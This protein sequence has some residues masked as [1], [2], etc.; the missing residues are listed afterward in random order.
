MSAGIKNVIW[1]LWLILICMISLWGC[2][3]IPHEHR[4]YG[5]TISK[6]CP[7]RSCTMQSKLY[8]DFIDG[9][10]YCNKTHCFAVKNNKVY[11]SMN[12]A[13]T[14]YS[15]NNWQVKKIYGDKNEWALY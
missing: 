8:A 9:K 5:H 11:D 1:Y 4:I 12:M 7:P 3:T 13:Y 15:I 6:M 2:T 10:V 14:G